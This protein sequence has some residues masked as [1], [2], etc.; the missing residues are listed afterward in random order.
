[1]MLATMRN[2]FRE[3]WTK[4]GS[5]WMQVTFMIVNDL[6]F[7]VFWYLFFNEVG[8]V[9]G[10]DAD[11]ALLLLAILA[12]MA[13]IVMGLFS[14]TRRLGELIA[15][16]RVDAALAL[17]VDPLRHLIAR[18][19]DPALMGDLLFGPALFTALG[20]LSPQ[21]VAVFVLVSICGAAVFGA[22]LIV[23]GSLTFFTGGR[24]EQA[25][26]G[27]QAI[28]ILSS[29]PID[30]FGGAVRLALYTIVP[31]AFVT[32]IPTELVTEFDGRSALLLV[33]VAGSALL[34]ADIVFKAGLRRYRS[35]ALWTQA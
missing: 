34:A 4:R 8:E 33:T 16:G 18:T 17:P 12:T 1:M 6:T 25:E 26:L 7:V 3:A 10:W 31:A 22:F 11:K 19:V 23:L 13:G 9:R 32:G 24:G 35:G 15:D 21:R 2:A 29:Y 14:N 30:M 20:D 27:F 5:F 28:L